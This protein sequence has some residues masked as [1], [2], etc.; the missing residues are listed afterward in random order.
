MRI[1][2]MNNQAQMT[3]V[4]QPQKSSGTVMAPRLKALL[5]SESMNDLR[6]RME[7]FIAQLCLQP[8]KLGLYLNDVSYGEF[9]GAMTLMTSFRE[10]DFNDARMRQVHEE[11][12]HSRQFRKMAEK[13]CGRSLTFARKDSLATP[14]TKFWI[15]K[16]GVFV[17]QSLASSFTGAKLMAMTSLYCAAIIEVRTTWLFSI[18]SVRTKM[19]GI[20][21]PIESILKDEADHINE[22][23][24]ELATMDSHF[25]DRMSRFHAFDCKL[26]HRYYIGNAGKMDTKCV[27]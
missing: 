18:I 17:R 4:H 15:L 8:E 26:F 19:N 14:S 24:F 1:L 5:Y 6:M 10:V 11:M 9:L 13:L 20:H 12:K 27:G 21:L 3:P 22:L 25:E 23:E 7:A 2:G 16:L